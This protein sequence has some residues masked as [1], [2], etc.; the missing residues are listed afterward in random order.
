MRDK[1]LSADNCPQVIKSACRICHSLEE[2]GTLRSASE[3]PDLVHNFIVKVSKINNGGEAD[4][5]SWLTQFISFI[6]WM[7]IIDF[8]CDIL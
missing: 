1:S 6:S 7:M 5:S 2:T 8:V 4:D 3:R